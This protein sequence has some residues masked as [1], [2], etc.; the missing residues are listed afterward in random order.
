MMDV[1]KKK[2]KNGTCLVTGISVWTTWTSNNEEIKGHGSQ[3][4]LEK[5]GNF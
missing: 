2:N 4:S 5:P 3:S 1:H